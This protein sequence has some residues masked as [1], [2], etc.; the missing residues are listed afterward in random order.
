MLDLVSTT[1]ASVHALTG[2]SRPGA[3]PP[4]A[5]IATAPA[6]PVTVPDADAEVIDLAERVTALAPR[7][8]RVAAGLARR[9]DAVQKGTPTLSPVPQPA[10]RVEVT[11]SETEGWYHTTHSYPTTPDEEH[12]A[13]MK[14]WNA[15]VSAQKRAKAALKARLRV[16][17]WEALSSRTSGRLV[18]WAW[19][20]TSLRPKTEAGLKAKAAAS[21]AVLRTHASDTWAT[22]L[23]A[24]VSRDALRIIG[25]EAAARYEEDQQRDGEL[26]A[27]GRAWEESCG[28]YERACATDDALKNA[29]DLIA[30]PEALFNRPEETGKLGPY[31]NKHFSSGRYWYGEAGTIDTLRRMAQSGRPDARRDEILSAYDRWKA[32]LAAEN[33]RSGFTAAQ[34]E[35]KAACDENADLRARIC[36]TPAR[37]QDGVDLKLRVILW[38]HDDLDTLADGMRVENVDHPEFSENIALS[39]VLD[40]VRQREGEALSA[41]HEKHAA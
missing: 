11:T 9:E 18:R 32:D 13:A 17:Q 36:L 12:A 7:E 8:C 35:L 16:P 14:V 5:P 40:L 38:L 21:V 15:E 37:T 33:E 26:L 30:P 25:A 4:F 19:K 31:P 39:L 41:S 23:H 28:R 2:S 24:S 6:I 22:A 27:L 34:A 10:R 20:L 1:S 29:L 3:V